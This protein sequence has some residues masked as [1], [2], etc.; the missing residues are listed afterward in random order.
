[1]PLPQLADELGPPGRGSGANGAGGAA[2]QIDGPRP[3]RLCLPLVPGQ[4]GPGLNPPLQVIQLGP[5]R[6][7]GARPGPG[8]VDQ[9]ADPGPPAADR[10]PPVLQGG[11]QLPGLALAVAALA[12]LRPGP[13]LGRELTLPGRPGGLPPPPFGRPAGALHLL[14]LPLRGADPDTG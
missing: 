11:F 4:I 2:P 14:A 6:P 10:V 1:Q 13:L 3:E 8:V 12:F 7:R 9:R 5:E